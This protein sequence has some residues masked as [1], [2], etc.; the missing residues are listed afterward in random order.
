MLLENILDIVSFENA[1]SKLDI[2]I[3]SIVDKKLLRPV[4]VTLQIA[5]SRKF[6][7]HTNWSPKVSFKESVKKLLQEKRIN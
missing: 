3:K 4:D 6:K 7:K 1:D 5:D 2:K